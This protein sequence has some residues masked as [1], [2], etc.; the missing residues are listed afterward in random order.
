MNSLVDGSLAL[1]P[2]SGAVF[3]NL[4]HVRMRGPEFWE[5]KPTHLAVAWVE[6]HWSGV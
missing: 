5:L 2:G 4:G 6:K 1:R 3:L